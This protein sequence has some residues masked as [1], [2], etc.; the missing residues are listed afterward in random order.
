VATLLLLV[1]YL[2]FI[3]LGIPDS[4]FGAAW[5]AIYGEF[6]LPVSYANFV[7][8]T[9]SACTFVSSLVSARVIN[10]F[11]TDKVTAV[12]TALT[13]AAIFAMSF[14]G[15]YF[16]MPLLANRV[17][18]V[19]LSVSLLNLTGVS[20]V[21]S[22]LYFAIVIGLVFWGILTLVLQNFDSFIWKKSKN[23]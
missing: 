20:T 22:V 13:A 11:G 9:T 1:I 14:S 15:N 6:N 10:R 5:P 7:T 16:F 17:N 18:G 23:S 12:S 8:L 4:L 19:V 3:G 2:A 21:I